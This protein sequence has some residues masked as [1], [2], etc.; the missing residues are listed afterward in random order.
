MHAR[1][2]ANR[3]CIDRGPAGIREAADDLLV[4]ADQIDDPTYRHGFL[5]DVAVNARILALA[6]DWLG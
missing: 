3:D 6:R 1:R 2:D 4:R 5:N